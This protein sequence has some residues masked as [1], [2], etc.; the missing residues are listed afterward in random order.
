MA[1]PGDR[2]GPSKLS[3]ELE[4]GMQ[5]AGIAFILHHGADAGARSKCFTQLPRNMERNNIHLCLQHSL[6]TL[7]FL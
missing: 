1:Q 7:N 6:V 5:L 4:A 3:V 2:E